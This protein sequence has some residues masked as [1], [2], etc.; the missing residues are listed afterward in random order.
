MSSELC[1]AAAAP[2]V[3]EIAQASDLDR[4]GPPDRDHRNESSS[5]ITPVASDL[6]T[7]ENVHLAVA[8]TLKTGIR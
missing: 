2:I 8:L 7:S 1:D 4:T 6:N 3:S 5:Q